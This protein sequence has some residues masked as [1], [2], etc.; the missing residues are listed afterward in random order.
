M[1][2]RTG[3]FAESWNVAWRKK[4]S[5]SI[6]YDKNTPFNIIKNDFR[7]WA[8][9]PFLLEFQNETY[10]FAELYDYIHC[11]GSLGYCKLDENGRSKWKQ[12]ILEDYHLSYPYIVEKDN[13]I[14]IIPESGA[15]HSLYVY[16]AIQFPD[17]WKK[18]KVLRE[19]V[20]YGDTTPFLWNN[21]PYALTYDVKDHKKYC[22]IVLDLED[23]K[24]DTKLSCEDSEFRRPAGMFFVQDNQMIRPAQNCKNDYG[25]GLIFYRCGIDESGE[26][27]EKEIQRI[28]PYELKYSRNILLDGMHTYNS[29]D[30]YEIIDIKTRRFN[31]LN[32][33]FRII[34]KLRRR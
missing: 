10:V 20:Q 11:R 19:N 14:Y 29:S 28:A 1:L 17:I 22:L 3:L 31:F 2:E 4:S 12:I 32:F 23:A 9:D 24:N 25:E 13:E 26:Y 6:L 21:H 7:Y 33:I 8:A 5:G 18:I 34:C 16:K 27:W 30:M 15:N